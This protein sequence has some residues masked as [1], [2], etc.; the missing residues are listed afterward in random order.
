MAPTCECGREMVKDFSRVSVL[1]DQTLGYY[2][3]GLGTYITS[4]SHRREV[5][6]QGGWVDVKAGTAASQV[7]PKKEKTEQQRIEEYASKIKDAAYKANIPLP[8]TN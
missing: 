2:D 7:K 6:K 5:M 8:G 4:T 1:V 3:N